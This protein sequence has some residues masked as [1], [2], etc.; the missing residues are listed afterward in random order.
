ML[1]GADK[2]TARQPNQHQVGVGIAHRT[3][4][5]VGQRR[6]F[7]RLVVQHAMR[8]D[9]PQLAPGVY[10]CRQRA[11]LVQHWRRPSLAVTA[12][13]FDRNFPGPGSSGV[14]Q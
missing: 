13:R 9:V 14:R 3:G 10:D 4:D 5:S 8:F 7:R 6:L 1:S 2:L 11:N 12:S